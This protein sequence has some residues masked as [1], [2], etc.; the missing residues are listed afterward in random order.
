MYLGVKTS[1]A[2]VD[3]TFQP[4]L[5]PFFARTTAASIPFLQVSIS[6]S[7]ER[8]LDNTWI[9]WPLH[10]IPSLTRSKSCPPNDL[11]LDILA[12]IKERQ[13][14]MIHVREQL[15]RSFSL[16][17]AFTLVPSSSLGS[18]SSLLG[19]WHTVSNLGDGLDSTLFTRA[20]DR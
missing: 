11:E 6:R 1:A 19:P 10:E 16:N 15:L 17:E 18:T 9:Q 20:I 12:V 7:L 13:F 3:L 4:A 2:K 14:A 5:S 8:S